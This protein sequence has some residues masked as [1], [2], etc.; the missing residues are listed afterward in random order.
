MRRSPRNSKERRMAASVRGIL[1]SNTT[2]AGD[3]VAVVG[4]VIPSHEQSEGKIAQSRGGGVVGMPGHHG[5]R[6]EAVRHPRGELIDTVPSG[7][8]SQ[9]VDCQPPAPRETVP[10]PAGKRQ[11]P[12]ARYPGQGRHLSRGGLQPENPLRR[13]PLPRNGPKPAPECGAR[14]PRAPATPRGAGPERGPPGETSGMDRKLLF[15][16]RWQKAVSGL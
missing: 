7:R 4:R 8:V 12:P 10:A 1:P 9:K 13:A 2:L 11:S 16:M 5:G 6:G 14:S 15:A 3:S